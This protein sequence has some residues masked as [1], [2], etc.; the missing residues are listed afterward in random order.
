MRNV[1]KQKL[2]K[3]LESLRDLPPQ[4]VQSLMRRLFKEGL[5]KP[6]TLEGITRKAER[7]VKENELS[8]EVVDEAIEWSRSQK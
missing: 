5:Y 4:E 8:P 3:I 1:T 7:I 6:P 2:D